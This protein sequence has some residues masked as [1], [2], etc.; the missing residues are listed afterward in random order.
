VRGVASKSENV[1][2]FLDKESFI[3]CRLALTKSQA[4]RTRRKLVI[5]KRGA[6]VDPQMPMRKTT[7]LY[8][9]RGRRRRP[10][11]RTQVLPGGGGGCRG[12]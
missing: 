7:K 1:S 10:L 6:V 9:K 4:K 11:D 2:D 5:L 8:G 12:V 3:G